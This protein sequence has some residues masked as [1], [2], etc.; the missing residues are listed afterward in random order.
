MSDIDRTKDW[1]IVWVPGTG[2]HEVHAGFLATVTE[3][4]GDSVQVLLVD[5]PASVDFEDSVPDG[6]AALD[7]MLREIAAEKLPFQRV[8]VAGSSQG[9][10][11]ISEGL[12]LVSYDVVHKTVCFGLPG[13]APPVPPSMAEHVWVVD[14]PFDAVTY[15]WVGTEG[16]IV[17]HASLAVQGAWWNLIPLVFYMV[18]SPL[19]SWMLAGLILTHYRI[20]RLSPHDYTPQMPLAVRWMTR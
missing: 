2:G 14:S 6:R 8:A 7:A 20:P 1:L 18:L 19:N 11:V 3:Q 17:H 5:Y 12:D 16:K 9:S 13:M 10:W 15:G 4:L